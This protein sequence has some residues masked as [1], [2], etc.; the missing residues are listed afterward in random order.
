VYE[1][2]IPGEGEETVCWQCKKTLVRRI[3]FSVRENLV[4]DGKCGF[5]GVKLDGV[6]K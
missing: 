3:G 4:R 2:N 6:W 5:C 1:G